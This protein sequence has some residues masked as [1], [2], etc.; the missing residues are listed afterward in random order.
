MGYKSERMQKMCQKKALSQ[1]V[2]RKK[3]IKKK[4]FGFALAL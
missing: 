2:Q 1:I 3:K 4:D